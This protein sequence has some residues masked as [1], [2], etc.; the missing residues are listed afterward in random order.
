MR[1]SQGRT[2][3]DQGLDKISGFV[4]GLSKVIE[5]LL[6]CKRW[7]GYTRSYQ[8]SSLDHSVT[9]ALLTGHLARREKEIGRNTLDEAKLIMHALVHDFGEGVTGD[10]TFRFKNDP[11]IKE[12][13]KKIE[14]EETVCQIQGVSI[15]GDYLFKAFILEPDSLERKFFAA[16][17]CLDYLLFAISEYRMGNQ[18]FV[19]VFQRQHS[20]LV[21]YI[22]LFPS[23]GEIYT[24]EV[25]EWIEGRLKEHKVYLEASKASVPQPTFKDLDDISQALVA[26]YKSLPERER[27]KEELLARL[28]EGLA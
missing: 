17:E 25:Q 19:K 24:R 22:S 10:L 14:E 13:Y 5:R 15:G 11:R 26:L 6:R 12:L 3:A 21:E 1:T 2:E 27:H 23:I 20:R 18:E 8:Q 9:I 16:V 4:Q 28:E 7:E